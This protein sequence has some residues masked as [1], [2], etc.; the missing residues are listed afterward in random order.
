MYLN[1]Q[2]HDKAY[3]ASVEH[4]KSLMSRSL[5]LYEEAGNFSDENFN[6]AHP[7]RLCIANYFSIFHYEIRDSVGE[8]LTFSKEAHEKVQPC[9]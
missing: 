4:K 8:A 6:Q 9:L 5:K 7:V 3:V 2:Y 1:R